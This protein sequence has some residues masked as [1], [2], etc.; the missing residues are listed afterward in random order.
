M[1][2]FRT[3]PSREC[4]RS[5]SIMKRDR[6]GTSFHITMSLSGAVAWWMG[7]R[8]LWSVRKRW[9]SRNSG[10]RGKS[11]PRVAKQ[12]GVHESAGRPR[13][14]THRSLRKRWWSRKS[15]RAGDQYVD[16]QIKKQYTNAWGDQGSAPTGATMGQRP[17]KKLAEQKSWGEGEREIT[18]KI[19]KARSSTPKQG[20]TKR[21]HP[22]GAT[23][24]HYPSDRRALHVPARR[25]KACRLGGLGF[26]CGSGLL[27]REV[28][29]SPPRGCVL[30]VP[31]AQRA[32]AVLHAAQVTAPDGVNRRDRPILLEVLPVA[33]QC[34]KDVKHVRVPDAVGEERRACQG[35]LSRACGVRHPMHVHSW[36]RAFPQDF[37]APRQRCQELLGTAEGIL[38]SVSISLALSFRLSPAALL[39][40][41]G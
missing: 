37:E 22:P 25:A 7:G 38:I 30:E 13:V 26:W 35:G 18:T 29:S 28:G 4:M 19:S 8:E 21:E 1:K 33:A 32:R 24:G 20:G 11:I 14:S 3:P 36:M 6:P 9:R 10:A 39:V 12:D 2:C 5:P 17:A 34:P 27:R 23:M 16:Q 15:R 40:C 41:T 31:P